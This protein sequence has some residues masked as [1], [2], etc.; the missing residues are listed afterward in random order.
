MSAG[1]DNKCLRSIDINEMERFFGGDTLS[2]SSFSD[3]IFGL[4]I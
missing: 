3:Y 4:L 1:E 2:P